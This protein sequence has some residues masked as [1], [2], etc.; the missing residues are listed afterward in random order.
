MKYAIGIQV[1]KVYEIEVEANSEEEALAIAESKQSTEI[2][3]IGDLESA[4]TDF[5]EIR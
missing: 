2:E 4:E 3:S 1:I 5:A